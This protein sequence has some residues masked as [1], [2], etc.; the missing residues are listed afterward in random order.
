MGRVKPWTNEEK[1]A[2]QAVVVAERLA[3][4]LRGKAYQLAHAHGHA[5]SGIAKRLNVARNA[6]YMPFPTGLT[7]A[8]KRMAWGVA[9]RIGL[10]LLAPEF[11]I[12]G[13]RLLLQPPSLKLM[14]AAVRR[15]ECARL[16][17]DVRKSEQE[18]E[19]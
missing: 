16:Y 18:G 19:E 1:E 15:P 13:S 5:L 6:L 17:E 2:L 14:E 11:H 7:S 12:F 10:A 4:H 3:E 8:E 9:E